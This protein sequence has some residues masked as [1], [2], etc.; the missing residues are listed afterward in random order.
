MK[1]IQGEARKNGVALTHMMTSYLDQEISKKSLCLLVG[2]NG[3]LIVEPHMM[4]SE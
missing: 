1:A 2:E 3:K 4:D